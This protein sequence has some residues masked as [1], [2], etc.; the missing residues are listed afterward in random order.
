[1]METKPAKTIDARNLEPPEPFVLT[2]EALDGIGP[3]EKLLLLL[4]REPHPLYRALEVNGFTY[5]T[6]RTAEGVVE[7]TIWRKA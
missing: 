7:I 3:D 5:Q 1:M 6:E 2:M 4:T